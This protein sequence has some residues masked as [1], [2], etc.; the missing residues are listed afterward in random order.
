MR[1]TVSMGIFLSTIRSVSSNSRPQRSMTVKPATAAKKGPA[2]S[3]AMYRSTIR[4]QSDFPPC[5]AARPDYRRIVTPALC[6][7]L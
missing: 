2:N 4:I 3:L 6:S 5:P 7:R 1:L